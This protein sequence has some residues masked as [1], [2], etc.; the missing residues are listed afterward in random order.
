MS[1]RGTTGRYPRGGG[2]TRC[3]CVGIVTR[4]RENYEE[5]AKNCDY[6]L[7]VEYFLLAVHVN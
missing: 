2:T 4:R 6:V 3:G 7:N 5:V 1:A